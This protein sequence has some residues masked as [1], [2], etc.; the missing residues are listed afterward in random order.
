MT[1]RAEFA[2]VRKLGKSRPG[3]YLV[4]SVL[5]D[6]ELEHFKLGLIVT[7]KVGKAHE[8]NLLRRRFRAIVQNYGDQLKP[9][10]RIVTIARWRAIGASYGELERDWL[11]LARYFELFES[12]G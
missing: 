8:R 6:D 12:E 7:K 10:Y 9:G 1:E 5:R 2:R 4:V 3:R 11:R